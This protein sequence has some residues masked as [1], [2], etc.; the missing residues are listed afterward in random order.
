MVVSMRRVG[1]KNNTSPRT[2]SDKN[3]RESTPIRFG[4]Y[5]F[6]IVLVVEEKKKKM[7]HKTSCEL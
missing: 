1:K 4:R 5:Y 7:K 2:C 3:A 6:C